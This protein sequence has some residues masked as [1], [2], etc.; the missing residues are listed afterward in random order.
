MAKIM[1]SHCKGRGLT[2]ASMSLDT[3]EVVY[4][5][6]PVC[7]GTGYVALEKRYFTMYPDLSLKNALELIQTQGKPVE[8]CIGEYDGFSSIRVL[9]KD[10]SRYVLGGFTVGYRGTGPDYTK[11]FLDAAGFDI[12]IDEIA[13]MK[14]PV[15]LVAGQPYIA[16]KTLVFSATTLE[17]ARRT[18]IE[19]VSSDAKIIALEVVWD[20]TTLDTTKGEGVSEDVAFQEAKRWLP[21][22][23]EIVKK[24]A[25][26]VL[27][28]VLPNRHMFELFEGEGDSENAAFENAKSQLPQEWRTA[29]E[30]KEVLRAGSQGKVTVEAFS[31]DGA[32]FEVTRLDDRLFPRGAVIKSI[33]C[34]RKPRF[35]FFFGNKPGTYEVSW[36]LPWK[37]KLTIR[38]KEVTLT[39]RR[40]ATVEVRFQPSSK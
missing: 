11:Q 21:K 6:C 35:S 5:D 31:E 32:E 9:F 12:S 20:G 19:S 13:E 37:V 26:D 23:A 29:V 15:T 25:R 1:C 27:S 7:R 18:A 17:E 33:F 8:I 2:F 14:P 10:G 36:L 40:K 4:R 22:G 24:E 16:P 39:Y 30:G 3:G 34:T 28:S 38:V